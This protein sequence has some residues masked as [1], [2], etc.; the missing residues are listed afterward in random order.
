MVLNTDV[1]RETGRTAQ[2]GN[3]AAAGA[4]ADIVRSTLGAQKAK[5]ENE[6]YRTLVTGHVAYALV[7]PPLYACRRAACHAEDAARSDGWDRHHQ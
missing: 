3:I 1:Q 2:L 7:A 6:R 4:V 5:S